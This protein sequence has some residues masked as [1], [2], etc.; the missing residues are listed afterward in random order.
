MKVAGRKL[1]MDGADEQSGTIR[2]LNL[3]MALRRTGV[4]ILGL[5]L[6]PALMLAS[7]FVVGSCQVE[8]GARRCRFGSA[9]FG[10]VR[11]AGQ[12]PAD[13][14]SKRSH[15][16]WQEC[17]AL[18]PLQCPRPRQHHC[19]HFHESDHRRSERQCPGYRGQRTRAHARPHRR[20]LACV[21][22]SDAADAPDDRRHELSP[23]VG[24]ATGS[25]TL[26]RGFTTIRDLGGPVFGLKRAI[27]EGVIDRSAHLSLR[28]FHLANLG[29]WR[30]PVL[31]R[32]SARDRRSVEPLRGGRHRGHC[33]QPR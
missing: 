18:C 13:A 22:G 31:L 29:S 23:A 6:S 15:F 12:S 1:M 16:R 9:G 10:A 19:A 30:L 4:R 33:R 26:M 28:R 24:G 3:A 11:H 32:A 7:A 14:F 21:H 27:D 2:G 8:L 25:A 17:F 5:A 20:P